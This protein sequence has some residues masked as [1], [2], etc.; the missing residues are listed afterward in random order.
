MMT[1]DGIDISSL[2]NG[3]RV[4]L[5]ERLWRSLSGEIARNGPPD[6]HET[7]LKTRETE[8]TERA[9]LAQDWSVV[10]EEL[11]REPL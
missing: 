11:T 4:A 6:W 8:W 9:R 1:A 2:S 7:E 5:M 10:R 3:Q